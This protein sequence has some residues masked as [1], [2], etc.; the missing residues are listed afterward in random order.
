[1]QL[2]SPLWEEPEGDEGVAYLRHVVDTVNDFS[3]ELTSLR[4]ENN[5]LNWDCPNRDYNK[6]YKIN[7]IPKMAES[8]IYTNPM[9]T[10]WENK[11]KNLIYIPLTSVANSLV[12][13]V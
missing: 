1:M 2:L 8:H 5:C 6:I 4:D 3:T 9:A 7:N 13:N 10:P 12:S 11:I